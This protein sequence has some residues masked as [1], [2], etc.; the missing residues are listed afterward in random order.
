[1]GLEARRQ[2]QMLAELRAIYE[3]YVTLVERQLRA[4][5]ID[6]ERTFARMVFATL[7][8]LVLQQLFFGRPEETRQGI[9]ELRGLLRMVADR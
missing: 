7:D 8:G 6:R 5:G 9:E 1:M 3:E 4:V 2:S